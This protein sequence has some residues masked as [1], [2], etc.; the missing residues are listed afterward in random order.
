MKYI[1]YTFID[2]DTGINVFS[3]LSTD[4]V[5]LPSIE[6]LEFVWAKTSLYP[7]LT[8][9]FFGTCPD[10]S[11]TDIE[12]VLEVMTE[13]SWNNARVLENNASF[14]CPP[15]ISAK[16]LRLGFLKYNILDS[17]EQTV[18]LL[19]KNL[20][21]EWQ[22]ATTFYRNSDLIRELGT[23]LDI[24]TDKYMYI[25]EEG[26]DAEYPEEEQPSIIHKI[27]TEGIEVSEI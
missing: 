4:P 15:T 17:V 2:K 3:K 10:S 12:G 21:I 5:I 23:R 18:K 8:P 19:P 27:F 22:Y 14:I 24:I 6:G 9:E 7:T 16:N 26:L 11:N 20:Q 1:K 25:N 13:E